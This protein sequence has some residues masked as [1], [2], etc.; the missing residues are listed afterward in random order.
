MDG[1]NRT[2]VCQHCRE[3][4]E[5][6]EFYPNRPRNSHQ[7]YCH[8]CALLKK[9]EWAKANPDKIKEHKARYLTKLAER[10]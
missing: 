10:G 5:L 8:V 6:S 1:M 9:R 7:G 4:K 2:K 3:A